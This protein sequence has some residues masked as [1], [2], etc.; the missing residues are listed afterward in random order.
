MH[1]AIVYVDIFLEGY[2]ICG[3][4]VIDE[5]DWLV[6][7]ACFPSCV[8]EREAQFTV[9][10]PYFFDIQDYEAMQT[11]SPVPVFSCWNGIVVFKADPILPIH[12]RSNR[13]LSNNPLPFA[14]PASHPA[15]HDPSSQGP[16]PALTPPTRFR[17]S[18]PGECLSS[19]SFLL[20][21][22][23]RRVFNMQRI[24]T[25]PRVIVAYEWRYVYN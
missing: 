5:G 15:A 7:C 19:E 11:E 4:C 9:R 16:T 8:R 18:A 24:F 13:T 10:W 20:P 2:I 23:L 17:A 21:Y 1:F 22:D 6:F 12:L 3:S 25:N 14:L